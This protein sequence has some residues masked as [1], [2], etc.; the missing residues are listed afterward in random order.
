MVIGL[1]NSES[2][3]NETIDKN[4]EKRKEIIYYIK[5]EILNG[6][7]DKINNHIYK[8]FQSSLTIMDISELFVNDI[9]NKSLEYYQKELDKE[10]LGEEEAKSCEIDS[11][12][13]FLQD[14]ENNIT[15]SSKEKEVEELEEKIIMFSVNNNDIDMN[16]QNILE[17]N[18]ND[19]EKLKEIVN[20]TDLMNKKNNKT[21]KILIGEIIESYYNNINMLEMQSDRNMIDNI[22]SFYNNNYNRIY[23]E[24]DIINNFIEEFKL[25]VSLAEF[26]YCFY[27]NKKENLLKEIIKCMPELYYYKSKYFKN[28]YDDFKGLMKSIEESNNKIYDNI[29][30]I[31]RLFIYKA[32]LTKKD[33]NNFFYQLFYLNNFF[34]LSKIFETNINISFD[35]LFNL[36]LNININKMY[37][38]QKMK[39]LMSSKY[40]IYYLNFKL[41][42]GLTMFIKTEEIIFDQEQPFINYRFKRLVKLVRDIKN[43][44]YIVNNKIIIDDINKLI[45]YIKDNEINASSININEIIDLFDITSY[46]SLYLFKLYI[47]NNPIDDKNFGH[48]KEKDP[49]DF[50]N[51]ILNLYKFTLIFNEISDST[52]NLKKML[53]FS[54]FNIFFVCPIPNIPIFYIYKKVNCCLLNKNSILLSN[55]LEGTYLDIFIKNNNFI[56]EDAKKM[57]VVFDTNGNNLLICNE[58]LYQIFMVLFSKYINILLEINLSNIIMPKDPFNPKYIYDT[59]ETFFHEIIYYF[60]SLNHKIIKDEYGFPCVSAKKFWKNIYKNCSDVFNGLITYYPFNYLAKNITFSSFSIY[61]Y[62]ISFFFR[63]VSSPQVLLLFI[64]EY[65]DRKTKED[66]ICYNEMYLLSSFIKIYFSKI[67]LKKFRDNLIYTNLNISN[68]NIDID[69]NNLLDIFDKI[70]SNHSLLISILL[71]RILLPYILNIISKI[72]EI[73]TKIYH[74]SNEAIFDNGVEIFNLKLNNESSVILVTEYLECLKKLLKIFSLDWTKYS[75]FF[76]NRKKIKNKNFVNIQNYNFYNYGINKINIDNPNVKKSIEELK[77]AYRKKYYKIKIDY[78]WNF[79][80]FELLFHSFYLTFADFSNKYF[81][82]YNEKK[83]ANG[84][85]FYSVAQNYLNYYEQND[86]YL[87]FINENGAKINIIREINKKIY[88]DFKY[89]RFNKKFKLREELIGQS[90]YDY[91][92][93]EGIQKIPLNDT[94]YKS[95]VVNYNNDIDSNKKEEINLVFDDRYRNNNIFVNNYNK[96]NISLQRFLFNEYNDDINSK[97]NYYNDYKYLLKIN[98]II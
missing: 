42:Y 96:L 11:E 69:Y 53:V 65:N 38:R 83:F 63:P 5:S 21:N 14:K 15:E 20:I 37:E 94:S 88:K 74:F 59:K 19:K 25:S 22:F 51:I 4:D 44:N 50:H 32:G 24:N 48:L 55:S 35:L 18:L 75:T 76:K 70:K 93:K 87:N 30:Y 62:L 60:T 68:E 17:F 26:I 64:Q 79:H 57:T 86:Y 66:K 27:K 47:D 33:M 89:G 90:N 72:T 13:G 71:L 41:R 67:N 84:D 8:S 40:L 45:L 97:E 6:I 23:S 29:I 92:T 49:K 52:S 7:F 82:K 31:S 77:Y 28:S 61:N 98:D 80:F 12:I 85:S 34:D 78:N 91:M 43:Q 36:T 16:N 3:I 9:I 10:Y 2:D 58:L 56:Y 39:E 54:L 1:K 81:K 46:I 95:Y 73:D